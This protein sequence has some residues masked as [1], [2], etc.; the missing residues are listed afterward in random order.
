MKSRHPSRRHLLQVV[1]ALGTSSFAAAFAQDN[2]L[3]RV[4]IPFPTGGNGDILARLLGKHLGE[5]LNRT[6]IVEAK[7]GAATMIGSE[8]VARATPDG[9]TLLLTSSSLM[10]L[11]LS[12]KSSLRFAVDKDLVPVTQAV[13]LPLVLVANNDAPFKTVAEMIAWAKANPDKLNVGVSPGLGG[14]SHLAWERLRLMAGITGIAVPYQGGAPVVQALL[15]NQVP[16][17]VE[18]VAT[19]SA[20][21]KEGKL[22][23][24][25]VLSEK[26]SIAMPNVPT[27]AEQ[28]VPGY[29]AENWMGFLA[30]AGT[31]REIITLLQNEINAVLAL[32]DVRARILQ[33]GMEPVGTTSDAFARN[34]SA[35]MITWAKVVQ[36]AGV[37]FD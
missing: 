1:A 37:K 22:R 17:M 12:K 33:L 4:I 16:V 23:M 2:K 29:E 13:M 27:A 24:L 30:P 6:V 35:G 15:G 26:R 8:F 18:G 28:G 21:V 36:E 20:L 14:A 25:A 34:I 9:N 7:P 5:R 10:T 31:P 3:M 19:S 11:P 32:P